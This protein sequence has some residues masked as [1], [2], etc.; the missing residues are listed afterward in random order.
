M[1][2]I[3]STIADLP[4]D[5]CTVS[6]NNDGSGN[7]I[8]GLYAVGPDVASIMGGFYPAGGIYLGP[9]MTFGYIAGRHAAGCERPSRPMIRTQSLLR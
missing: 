7:P 2:P 8:S 9:A 6:A 5:R 3:C 4:V 1:T